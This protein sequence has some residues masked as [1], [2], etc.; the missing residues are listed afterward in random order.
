MPG[1]IPSADRQFRG[2][3][4][5]N[6]LLIL[7]LITLVPL[8]LVGGTTYL[9]TRRL[10]QEQIFSLMTVIAQVQGQRISDEIA[11]GR[12]LLTR[13]VVNA[14]S[15]QALHAALAIPDRS[16]P[17]YIAAR[18]Q[19]F[20]QIQIVNQPRPYF[21]QFI[22]VKTDGVIHI[23]TKRSWEGLK[24]G[25]IGGSSALSRQA[26]SRAVFDFSPLYQQNLVI[27]T[28]IPY[29]NANEEL[30][31]TIVGISEPT[32]IRDFMDRAAFFAKSNYLVPADGVYFGVNPYP[33]SFDKLFQYTPSPELNFFLE[34]LGAQPEKSGVNELVS[35]RDE[36]V[37]AAYTWLPDLQAGL[38]AEIPQSSVYGQINSLLLFGGILLAVIGIVLGF[39]VWQVTRYLVRPLTQLASSVSEFSS[40]N[41]Y[42]RAEVNRNDEVGLLANSF[43]KM[44]ADLSILYQ[45]L[46][47]KVAERTRQLQTSGELSQLSVSA[48][49]LDEL[50][51]QT[52]KLLGTRFGYPF[53]AIYLLDESKEYAVLRQVVAP[54]GIMSN[55]RG[56]RIKV[57]PLTLVGWVA[58]SGSTK[59]D[60]IGQ[61]TFGA[62]DRPD[63]APEARAEAGIPIL[64]SGKVLGVLVVQ[65]I[66]VSQ[67]NEDTVN[68]LQNLTNQI[69]PALQNF[70]L[71]EATQ[72]DLQETNLLYQ[73]SHQIAQAQNVTQIYNLAKIALLNTPYH[74]ALLVAD[75]DHFN[76]IWN[77]KADL[78][79]NTVSTL[80]IDPGQVNGQLPDTGPAI[81]SANQKHPESLPHSLVEW[82]QKFGGASLALIPVRRADE[83]QTIL[84]LGSGE[85]DARAGMRFSPLHL[86]PYTNLVELMTNTLEKV[87]ALEATQKKLNEMEI[88]NNLSREVALQ[89]NLEALFGT[90]YEYVT[91]IFGTVDFLLA[92][93]DPDAHRIQVPYAIEEGQR[94]VVPSIPY[95]QGLTSM[96]I[97]SRKTLRLVTPEDWHALPAGSVAIFGKDAVSWLGAPMIVGGEVVGVIV[98][99]D[100]QQSQRFSH[101]DE[102]FF[103]TL[104]TQLAVV[105]RNMVLLETT[106]QRA[107]MESLLNEITGNIRR[108]L[109]I[110][111]ILTTTTTELGHA[112]RVRKTKITVWA[113]QSDGLDQTTLH[114]GENYGLKP[115]RSHN[116]SQPGEVKHGD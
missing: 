28:T 92:R 105:I 41:W 11:A 57:Q 48:A 65:S 107:H 70:Y 112:L 51:S 111:D 5:R 80:N 96:V 62:I 84:V 114:K 82:L 46:E 75:Q 47:S 56:A 81:G 20:D 86:Q 73:T 102:I 103:S 15:I 14:E 116:L 40:G 54:P 63:L 9:Q 10:L 37:I 16:Q 1:S 95:G 3:L 34:Y 97:R 22:V 77:S 12:Q 8:F 72:I 68:E 7:L 6:T 50:L 27:L 33:D 18:N 108:S 24:L 30:V 89:T 45:S 113:P 39:I 17:E 90:I 100:V 91:R 52:V 74:S 59:V 42:A 79:D 60:L 61:G 106:R 19:F 78:P 43:N 44:A 87:K 4:A 29:L 49:D 69:G 76:V 85:K 64:H 13:A 23:S 26:N 83:L 66:R 38:L 21:S 2:R 35:F 31:A 94:L 55:I 58:M 110:R 25:S 88:L 71:L 32:V 104:A 109:S 53:V 67:L 93:F 115:V 99:Q 98:V 36:Q 101:D